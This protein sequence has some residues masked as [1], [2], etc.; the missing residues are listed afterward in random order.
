MRATK[1]ILIVNFIGL[2]IFTI[3]SLWGL[4]SMVQEEGGLIEFFGIFFYFFLFLFFVGLFILNFV[5]YMSVVK[6]GGRS[7]AL[8]RNSVII[9]ILGIVLP[10]LYLMLVLYL[11]GAGLPT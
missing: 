11:S 6:Y 5:I 2:L 10:V 7:T 9:L 4:I 1:I 8:L 3:G